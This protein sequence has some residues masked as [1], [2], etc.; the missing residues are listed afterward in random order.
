MPTP[1]CATVKSA[2]T[3][4]KEILSRNLGN[5]HPNEGKENSKIFANIANLEAT[6]ATIE[7]KSYAA[8]D[9]SED[10]G[11]PIITGLTAPV[12]S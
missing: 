7:E 12:V 5:N 3:D 1:H 6:I 9:F 10:M 8:E 2:L 4:L 11:I